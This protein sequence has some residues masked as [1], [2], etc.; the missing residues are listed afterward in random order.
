VRVALARPRPAKPRADTLPAPVPAAILAATAALFV[1]GRRPAILVLLACPTPISDTVRRAG[2]AELAA[3][4]FAA[5]AQVLPPVGAVALG[6]AA[7]APTPF[8]NNAGTALT[9]ARIAPGLAAKLGLK[10]APSWTAVESGGACDFVA[11]VGHRRNTL[12]IGPGGATA[13]ATAGA[14]VPRL[15]SSSGW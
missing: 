5:L 10:P 1:W 12:V 4:G 11:P 8:L 7:V 14:R 2:G 3:G 9:M 13:P 6:S 15:R